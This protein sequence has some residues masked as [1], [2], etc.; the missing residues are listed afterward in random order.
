MTYSTT[1]NGILKHI[2]HRHGPYL[3]EINLCQWSRPPGAFVTASQEREFSQPAEQNLDGGTCKKVVDKMAEIMLPV[4]GSDSRH[5]RSYSLK[6]DLTQLYWALSQTDLN[7][8]HQKDPLPPFVLQ[9]ALQGGKRT[10]TKGNRK[11]SDCSN[12][13]LH[14]ELQIFPHAKAW[15]KKTTTSP[16]YTIHPERQWTPPAQ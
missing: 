3:K 10:T 8:K 2:E 6:K 13:L 4:L 9:D 15:G 1:W 5:D 12:V 16:K 7:V 11:S 14:V